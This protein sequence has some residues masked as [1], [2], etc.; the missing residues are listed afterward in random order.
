MDRR[1][2]RRDDARRG[3][4]RRA[5]GDFS[6][7]KIETRREPRA[8]DR[9]SGR[10]LPAAVRDRTDELPAYQ[11]ME[12]EHRTVVHDDEYVSKEGIHTNQVE[13]L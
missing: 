12:H 1:A 13:C 6:R 7:R 2:G 11:Q 10:S 5:S 8:S 9:G 4:P 3:V